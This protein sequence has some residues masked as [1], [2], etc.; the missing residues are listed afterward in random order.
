[1]SIESQPDAN[2]EIDALIGMM[3]KLTLSDETPETKTEVAVVSKPEQPCDHTGGSQNSA[4][5]YFQTSISPNTKTTTDGNDSRDFNP[6][7]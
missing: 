5:T 6:T 7:Q 1:M 3:Q 2:E 4:S